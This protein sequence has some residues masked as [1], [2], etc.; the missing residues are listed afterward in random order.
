MCL[1][2]QQR[3]DGNAKRL[4]DSQNMPWVSRKAAPCVF[5]YIQLPVSKGFL[6][7]FLNLCWGLSKGRILCFR[8]R[9]QLHGNAKRLV[10]CD[11]CLELSNGR[12]LLSSITPATSWKREVIGCLGAFTILHASSRLEICPRGP[13]A[14]YSL[15]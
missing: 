2:S 6:V 8:S 15:A 5:N 4:V 3:F 13:D 14:T 11:V 12:I 7:H 10:D 9:H 1:R